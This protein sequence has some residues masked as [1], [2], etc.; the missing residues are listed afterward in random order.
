[1]VA[2]YA[3]NPVQQV[4]S[5]SYKG[6]LLSSEI[7]PLWSVNF[8]NDQ[9][10]LKWA[11]MVIPALAY[12]DSQRLWVIL[13]NR[14]F[15]MGLQALREDPDRVYNQYTREYSQGLPR[16]V[17]NQLYDLTEQWVSKMTRFPPK[18][19]VYPVNG[20]F[21]DRQSAKIS[22]MFIEHI[23]RVN[24]MDHKVERLAR[25]ARTDG[26]AWM[27]VGWNPEIG[28]YMPGKKAAFEKKKRVALV[29]KDGE[30]I[31]GETGSQLY[32]DHA[33][34]VGDVEYR[35][36]N[37][38]DI[39]LEPRDSFEDVNYSIEIRRFHID[40]L[41]AMYPE[42]ETAINAGASFGE[43]YRPPS[44]NR[45]SDVIVYD[46]YHKVHPFL[47]QGRFLRLV[48]DVV[49][50]NKPLPYSHGKLPYVRLC[51]IE[52]P[53]EIRGI[54][55]FQNLV[56][57]QVMYNQLF[58]LLYKNIA[59]GAH[60]FWLVPASSG[61]QMS[62]L[63]N[64]TTVIKYV[65]SQAP[66]IQTFKVVPPEVFNLLGLAREEMT[67]I[68][69]I[70]GI[71]RGEVPARADSGAF[72]ATL[73]EQE[74]QA[75][76]SSI[77]NHNRA[78]KQIA[79]LSLG[80][81]G[82]FYDA[83]D[84]RTIRIVGKNM[85]YE[86][87]ALDEA[88]LSGPYEVR[89]E[90][91][92]ALSESPATRFAQIMNMKQMFP[93]LL[94]DERAA[95]LLDLNDDRRFLSVV[96]QA[97]QAAEREIEIMNNGDEV[98]E[99]ERY[100]ALIV[101]WEVHSAYMQTRQFKDSPDDIRELHETHML[102]TEMLMFEKAFVEG[103]PA[104]QKHLMTLENYPTVFVMPKDKVQQDVS[105]A[106]SGQA[107]TLPPGAPGAS[108]IS[109]DLEPQ[110]LQQPEPLPQGTGEAQGLPPQPTTGSEPETL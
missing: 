63:R 96:T 64:A 42:K 60:L 49:L 77:K 85:E 62:A 54:S 36:V 46:I 100:E 95:D 51:D 92:S 106:P 11:N 23:F 50:E 24:D 97:V 107:G 69:R 25:T 29:D 33:P 72:L 71:S 94:S 19:S 58:A 13:N 8:E 30:P 35:K 66:Q 88:K 57:L 26:E 108:G 90:R 103:N 76:N 80:V 89:I 70:H 73:E 14:N 37:S 15:Y 91:S 99:P 52:A 56:L 3:S 65:G 28:D 109:D 53:G 4:M 110:P 102:T 43:T 82:D 1:M 10:I 59:L 84:G 67:R 31:V 81:A 61:M 39:L 5:R 83:D 41:K 44:L 2:D 34:R 79:E 17:A 22:Q 68:A 27:F 74:N 104:F 21:N 40:E 7:P 86:I 45:P 87:A 48:S 93:T 105:G 98:A 16:I 18:I 32:V 55:F 75:A 12:D 78:I 47:G 38:F 6:T 20:E 9:E 101:H